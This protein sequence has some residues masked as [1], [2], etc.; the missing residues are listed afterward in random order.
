MNHETPLLT[1]DRK[2]LWHPFTQH[3]TA[4]APLEVIRGEGVYLYTADGRKIL[5]AIGSWWVTLH[6]HSDARIVSRVK[7]QLDQLEHVIFAGCTHE[8]AVALA[9]KILQL[10]PQGFG[11]A[12]YSDNGSTSVEVALKMALQFFA[13]RGELKRKK[14]LAFANGYHGDTFGGMS[15]SGRGTFVAPFVDK[16]FDVTFVPAPTRASPRGEA[17]AAMEKILSASGD[18]YA[19][20][21]YE[22]LVQ[23]VAGMVMQDREELGAM[24]ELAQKH[25]VLCIADEVMTGFGRTG[26]I[27][28]SEQMTSF[29]DIVCL[30]KGL[31]GGMMAMGMT[32]ARDRIFDAFLSDDPA[33]TFLHGHSYTAN[34]LACTA[35]LAS[36][37]ILLGEESTAARQRIAQAHK[38]FVA[39]FKE[40]SLSHTVS[41]IRACGTILAVEWQVQGAG[42]FSH[43]RQRSYEF[44]LE[45]G[46][47]LRPLGNITY[48][49]P[50][51]SI[52]DNELVIIYD[53]LKAFASTV[54]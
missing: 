39:N 16:F 31:T 6:G 41:D 12:F 3:Q 1:R 54:C 28:A 52:Q 7:A 42:Y 14:I 17:L 10:F 43:I 22:P 27:F 45:R 15:V 47:L 38:T 11:K 5:D 4:I 29:P 26:T 34:P 32:V 2:A 53:A 25:G 24:I 50:P 13:N 44:F 40:S 36:I 51:Y 49:L 33:K 9:E 35:G 48:L 8:P 19:A 21:I 30:S 18:E 20:W 23:G 46:I 37:E